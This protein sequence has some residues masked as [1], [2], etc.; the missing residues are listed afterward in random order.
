MVTDLSEEGLLEL[1]KQETH[2]NR[3]TGKPLTLWQK[4]VI[5]ITVPLVFEVV[6]FGVLLSTLESTE[7]EMKRESYARSVN[8]H[9]NTAVRLIMDAS[10]CIYLYGIT[11]NVEYLKRYRGDRSAV[12]LELAA[13]HKLLDGSRPQAEALLNIEAVNERIFMILDDAKSAASSR[14]I[15]TALNLLSKIKELSARCV[16]DMD[17]LAAPYRK[18]AVSS[19]EQAEHSR[20][21]LKLALMLGIAISVLLAIWL[22]LYFNRETNCR[23]GVLLDNAV[24]FAQGNELNKPLNGADEIGKLDAVF[25]KMTET[26]KQTQQEKREMMAMITHDIRSPLTSVIGG[27]ALLLEPRMGINLEE[28]ATRIIDRAMN[29]LSRL[30]RLVNDLLDIEKLESGK[31]K[32]YFEKTPLA[33]IFVESFN[34]VEQQTRKRGI[35]IS[36]PETDVEIYADG[37]RLV[38]VLVNLLSNAIKYSPNESI[39]NI[40]AESDEHWIKISIV[41]QGPGI[42]AEY[43]DKMFQRFQQVELEERRKFGGTGLGLAVCKEIITAHG[44]TIGIDSAEGG[45]SIFWFCLPIGRNNLALTN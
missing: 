5:L 17:T 28:K 41:D 21:I 36:I 24:R 4:G 25:H 18:I 9:I 37:D 32:M 44:G 33:H 40:L 16:L 3:A 12:P 7:H 1:P 15:S 6:S 19:S 8:E 43:R 26:I 20:Q 39:I 10:S 31:M 22:H 42:P 34:I 30:M 35:K 2:S 14:D 45:G 13:L 23:L 38:Q 29:N 27:L 11:S